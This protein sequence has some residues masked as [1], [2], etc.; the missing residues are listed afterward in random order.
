MGKIQIVHTLHEQQA[1][2]L[3]RLIEAHVEAQV[4]LSWNGA[5]DPEDMPVVAAEADLAMARMNRFI[6]K[7]VVEGR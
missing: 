1:D 5:N 4:A 3:R 6:N 2:G 7:L